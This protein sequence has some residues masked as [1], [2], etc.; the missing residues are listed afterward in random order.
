[1]NKSLTFEIMRLSK[2]C[3]SEIYAQTRKNMLITKDTKVIIQV[4]Y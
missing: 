1:L 3:L 4:N 2:I